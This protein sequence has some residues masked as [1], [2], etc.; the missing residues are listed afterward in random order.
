MA[1]KKALGRPKQPEGV[2]KHAFGVRGREEWKDWVV[3]FANFRRMDLAD[4]IDESLVANAQLKGF[5]KEPPK[6]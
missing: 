3:E 6:R 4:L 1:K 2:R 5:T